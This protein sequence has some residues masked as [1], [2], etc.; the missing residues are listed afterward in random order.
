MPPLHIIQVAA[1]PYPS[2]QGSQVYVRGLSRALARRG[3]RVTIACYG[4]G[5]GEPDPEIRL[6]RTP[7][8]PGYRRTRAGPDLV[9][10][11]LDLALAARLR[12]VHADVIHAHNY[13]APLAVA[14]S[15]H[16]APMIYSAHNTMAEELP[17]YFS[18]W[19]FTGW[20]VTRRA[21]WVVARGAGVLLDR[22]V[23]R[24][25]AHAIAISTGGVPTLRALGCRSVSLVPPGVDPEDLPLAPPA[26]LPPG[27]WIGYA[28]NPD[29]Y[30]E[31][32]VLYAAM[33]HVR[34]GRLLLVGASP[35]RGAPRSAHVIQTTDFS[36]VRR[37]L[38][39]CAVAVLPRSVCTGFPIKLL[40][41]LGLGLPTVA[42]WAGAADL[43]GV[44][45]VP[46]R[47]PRALAEAIDALLTDPTRRAV[48]G[49]AAR[50]H[51]LTRCTWDARARDVERIYRDVLAATGQGAAAG[52]STLC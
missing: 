2:P 43:P 16:P 21:V 14:L 45:T 29:A 10:P 9:K 52:R 26:D 17:T 33:R 44:V 38:R 3:H 36:L 8:L 32:D 35:F 41:F 37:L 51:V 47:E 30:Q 12:G 24:M 15:C 7:R 40:N 6:L 18:G 27:P 25:A 46:P 31:L 20:G 39:G 50:K 42:A 4:H 34:G 22:T 11:L 49:A 19:G 48:L 13:E 5:I 28:G 23:P 1:F